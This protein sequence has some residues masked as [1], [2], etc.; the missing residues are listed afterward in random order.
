MSENWTVSGTYFESC[1][2]DVACPCIF[3]SDPTQGEC[4]ALV[5]WHID[6]GSSDG[7]SLSDLNVALGSIRA[8]IWPQTNGKRLFIWTSALRKIN[9]TRC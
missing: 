4:T 8:A 5:G 3:L 1:N 7:L 6:D 2:C 9:E